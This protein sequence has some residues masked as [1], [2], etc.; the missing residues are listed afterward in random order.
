MTEIKKERYVDSEPIFE[1]GVI[2]GV[3]HNAIYEREKREDDWYY[4]VSNAAARSGQMWITENDLIEFISRVQKLQQ[5]A[6]EKGEKPFE[7]EMKIYP[8]RID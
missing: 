7:A 2:P 6:V 8:K 5:E 1:L 4:L 3:I